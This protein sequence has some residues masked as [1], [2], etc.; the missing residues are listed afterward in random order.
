M[1][2]LK[3]NIQNACGNDD[4]RPHFKCVY[5]KNGYAYAI[6]CHILVRESLN[7]VHDMNDDQIKMLD[8]KM[9]SKDSFK[10]LKNISSFEIKNDGILVRQKSGLEILVMYSKDSNRAEFEAVIPDIDNCTFDHKDLILAIN[11]FVLKKLLSCLENAISKVYVMPN[12]KNNRAILMGVDDI[13]LKNILMLLMPLT[14]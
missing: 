1:N 12:E 2:F 8:D 11:P 9:I 6:D 3:T 13:P 14:Q 4:I 5:F 7:H 10:Y